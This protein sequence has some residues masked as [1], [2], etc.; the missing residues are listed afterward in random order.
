MPE[1]YWET[2]YEQY[3]LVLPRPITGAKSI[4]DGVI[5][6]NPW[7]PEGGTYD[8]PVVTLDRYR[9][10]LWLLYRDGTG[11]PWAEK[12]D[13]LSASVDG[14]GVLR[15]IEG[16]HAHYLTTD[17]FGDPGGYGIPGLDPLDMGA[18]TRYALDSYTG[19]GWRFAREGETPVGVVESHVEEARPLEET[20][21][22]FGP[23]EPPVL[24]P[25]HDPWDQP[26]EGHWDGVGLRW[27]YDE[28]T[29]K[30][31]GILDDDHT[32][33]LGERRLA[34]DQES[35]A[36]DLKADLD[37][38]EVAGPLRSGHW[39]PAALR[40]VPDEPTSS[41]GKVLGDESTQDPVEGGG[42]GGSAEGEGEPPPPV[43]PPSSTDPW[44]QPREGHWDPRSL[45][46]VPD[47]PT[48]S[49]GKVLDEDTPWDQDK[50]R[51]VDRDPLYEEIYGSPPPDETTSSA[52][53][54]LDEDTPWD[55][56]KPRPVDRDPFEL[57]PD[58]T[59]SSAGKV[60]DEDTPWDQ[61]R[62]VPRE[63][64]PLEEYFESE[65]PDETTSSVGKVWGSQPPDE[66]TSSV[67]KV[68][69]DAAGGVDPSGPLDQASPVR[70]G[71]QIE[72]PTQEPPPEEPPPPEPGDEGEGTAAAPFRVDSTSFEGSTAQG[73]DPSVPLDRADPN[74][75]SLDSSLFDFSAPGPT[76]D[77][78]L[79]DEAEP[80]PTLDR[81]LFD[82]N[83]PGPTLDAALFDLNSPGPTVD[84][85]LFDERSPGPTLD[86]GLLDHD[87]PGPTIDPNRLDPSAPGD[88]LD[89]AQLERASERPNSVEEPAD[90]TSRGDTDPRPMEEPAH[91]E[92]STPRHDDHDDS[93]DV[94]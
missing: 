74:L 86:P 20:T 66:T 5:R 67:G 80:G 58:E 73:F 54:V 52:G 94:G 14:E 48:S 19:L 21:P 85:A 6:I 61:P 45:Q 91:P 35:S 36:A 49:V 92:P 41:V 72:Q 64:T 12:Y 18:D 50:P 1:E 89:T 84:P 70:L 76:L 22:L 60:L 62:P 30:S 26:R 65:P 53:K 25:E 8:N 9:G 56:D 79:F 3:T 28:P 38:E 32:H 81:S 11:R 40:W 77:P 78:G 37:D 7:G 82:S 15:P 71:S 90:V 13:I 63:P 31:A 2:T 4:N 69:D 57:L 55:Q 47:E 51:P 27:V 24:E 83:A 87:A 44:D 88:T 34:A 33:T 10:D 16:T 46:W 93:L 39:D 68:L 42:A 75:Q 59:T 43:E 29:M 23:Q 17:Q